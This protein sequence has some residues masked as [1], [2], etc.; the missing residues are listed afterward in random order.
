MLMTGSDAAEQ[1][2]VLLRLSVS[3]QQPLLNSDVPA[4]AELSLYILT[5]KV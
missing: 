4:V 5:T 1:G 3:S 2:V